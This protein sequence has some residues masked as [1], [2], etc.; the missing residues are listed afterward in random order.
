MEQ[1]E[2]ADALN[3]AFPW[4]L[5]MLDTLESLCVDRVPWHEI[6]LPDTHPS[7]TAMRSEE[8]HEKVVGFV[9]LEKV[10]FVVDVL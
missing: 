7:I 1:P 8:S 5:P 2:D 4:V 6:L 10:D 9:G 3:A